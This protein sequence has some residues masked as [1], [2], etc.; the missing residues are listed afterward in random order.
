MRYVGSE[1]ELFA[2]AHNWKEYSLG[3]I[4]PYITGHVLEVGAGIAAATPYLISDTVSS[5]TCL[6]PDP[7]MAMQIA[8]KLTAG[9]LPGVTSVW[10]GTIRVFA[11]KRQFDS[12]LYLDVLEHIRDDRAELESASRLLM[13]GGRL[14]VLAPA[15]ERLYSEFD[16]AVGHYRRY[17]RS[18]LLKIAPSKLKMVEIYYIDVVGILASWANKAILRRAS[19][20]ATQIQVWDRYMIPLS[21]ALD[22]LFGFRWGKSIVGV[23]EAV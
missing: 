21:R 12:I 22:K 15:H 8:G 5:W 23:W 4:R 6:E 19:P 20:Q 16:T 17:C 9:T 18:S 14:I 11:G 7:D 10:V 13:P 1:L 2:L 3:L